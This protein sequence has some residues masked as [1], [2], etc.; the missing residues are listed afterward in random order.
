[1]TTNEYLL[2]HFVVMPQQFFEMRSIYLLVDSAAFLQVEV[3]KST[4]NLNE[5][6]KFEKKT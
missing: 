2:R 4:K 6:P 5:Q 3:L 1:M